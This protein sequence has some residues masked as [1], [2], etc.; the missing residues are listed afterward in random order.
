MDWVPVP[1]DHKSK[2]ALGWSKYGSGFG[3]PTPDWYWDPTPGAWINLPTSL[4]DVRDVNWPAVDHEQWELP[5]YDTIYRQWFHLAK[6]DQDVAYWDPRHSKWMRIAQRTSKPDP[7]VPTE[8]SV[9]EWR[10]RRFDAITAAKRVMLDLRT[11][12]YVTPDTQREIED[13]LDRELRL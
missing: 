8:P 7:K 2:F 12:R 1:G 13:A 9:D 10:R 3:N 4:Y 11:N 5:D 6:A